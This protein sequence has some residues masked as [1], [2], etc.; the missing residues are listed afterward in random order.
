MYFCARH[1]LRC[2]WAAA[3]AALAYSLYH[4]QLTRAATQEHITISLF[5]TFVPLVWWRFDRALQTGRFRD[6]FWCAVTV[7]F[8]MWVDNKQIFIQGVFLFCYLVYWLW[9]SAQRG[10]WTAAR[11][12]AMIGAVSLVLGAGILVPGLIESKD[13]KLFL[14]D[15]LEAWQRSYAFK[16]A[17]ALVDRDGVVT[18]EAVHGVMNLVRAGGF[19]PTSQ[20]EAT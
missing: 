8:A 3:L 6:A 13:V 19:R 4:E 15:P 18:R 20:Q 11:T 10:R 14:G 12:C 16:S 5:M 17:L 1:F 9:Q 7:V 2:E